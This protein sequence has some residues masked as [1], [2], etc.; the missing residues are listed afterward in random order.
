MDFYFWAV[1]FMSV[2]IQTN[3]NGA[4]L[5]TKVHDAT[6]RTFYYLTIQKNTYIFVTS[7]CK[8]RIMLQR[9]HWLGMNTT[10]LRISSTLTIFTAFLAN[11]FEPSL[12]SCKGL[13]SLSTIAVRQCD[14]L[15]YRSMNRSH[16][17][18]EPPRIG[19]KNDLTNSRAS[20]IIYR[21]MQVFIRALF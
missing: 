21:A 19:Q 4:S 11:S 13:K 20:K 9:L 10:F 6:R 15:K 12:P 16:V 7:I 14:H 2:L 18:K 17:G 5:L 3:F 1:F 8:K